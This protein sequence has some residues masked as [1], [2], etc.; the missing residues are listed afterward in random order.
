MITRPAYIYAFV[1][2]YISCRIILF[3]YFIYILISVCFKVQYK[4][5]ILHDTT[6]R[7]ASRISC[8][9]NLVPTTTS[10]KSLFV[11]Q[12]PGTNQE[13]KQ[14]VSQLWN[15]W[16]EDQSITLFFYFTV[17]SLVYKYIYDVQGKGSIN[18][19]SYFGKFKLECCKLLS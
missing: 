18:N 15:L 9:V 11:Q 8:F 2:I 14:S 10:P 16:L 4:F 12:V 7:V 5:L 6:S 3:A 1:V 17:F 13:Y 19:R